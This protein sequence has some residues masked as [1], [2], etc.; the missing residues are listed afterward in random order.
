MITLILQAL[1]Y[2]I[3]LAVLVGPVFFTLVN[4]GIQ[5]GIKPALNIASGMWISDLMMITIFINI[6]KSFSLRLSN[7]ATLILGMISGIVFILIGSGIIFKRNNIQAEVIKVNKSSILSFFTYGFVLNTIN[8][9][10]IIFWMSVVTTYIL[11][12]KITTFQS[13]IFFS[14]IMICIIVSDIIK[15]YLSKT[16]IKYLSEKNIY[17]FKLLCGAL[18]MISGLSILVRVIYYP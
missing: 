17:R 9:F 4:A 13:F 18:L 5:K 1:S 3:F 16:I 8:P 12:K 10:A 2:G 6:S 15:V 7:D 14:I 11:V